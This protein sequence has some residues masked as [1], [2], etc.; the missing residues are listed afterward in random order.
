MQSARTYIECKQTPRPV[1]LCQLAPAVLA[2]SGLSPLFLLARGGG[3][4]QFL[5][6]T[7]HVLLI[8]QTNVLRED[9]VAC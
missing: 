1:Q 8:I 7:P 5:V 4:E 9:R 6:M 2:N 3:R